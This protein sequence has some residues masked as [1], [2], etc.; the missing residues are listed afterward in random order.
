MRRYGPAMVLFLLPFAYDPWAYDV[1]TAKYGA[2]MV[3]VGLWASVR[4]WE[5][6]LPR[7]SGTAMALLIGLYLPSWVQGASWAHTWVPWSQ[8]L[9][10]VWWMLLVWDA[11]L[12]SEEPRVLQAT[13]L[14]ASAMGLVSISLLAVVEWWHPQ[15]FVW[16]GAVRGLSN[17]TMGNPNHLGALLSVGLPIF[18]VLGRR[19]RWGALCVVVG[20]ATTG[21]RLSLLTAYILMALGAILT[22]CFGGGQ[23]LRERLQTTAWAACCIGALWFGAKQLTPQKQIADIAQG[24][25][26]ISA[27]LHLVRCALPMS[28][29]ALPWGLGYGRFRQRFPAHRGRCLKGT[30]FAQAP[31]HTVAVNL[32]NDWLQIAL[33]GGL[34][35]VS[36]LLAV[37]LWWGLLLLRSLRMN[38][39]TPSAQSPQFSG[40][41]WLLLPMLGIFVQMGGTFPIQLPSVLALAT[42]CALSAQHAMFCASSVQQAMPCASSSRYT[43][44]CARFARYTTPFRWFRHSPEH[45]APQQATTD[46]AVGFYLKATL[47]WGYW[48]LWLVVMFVAMRVVRA[49]HL[50]VQGMRAMER[51]SSDAT[52]LLQQ[53]A[54]LHPSEQAL[55]QLGQA[56]LASRQPEPAI[57][58]LQRA[59][60]IFPDVQVALTLAEAHLALRNLHHARRDLH[61]ARRDL[62]HARRD[63]RHARL[64][65]LRGLALHPHHT[66]T[67][68]LLRHIQKITSSTKKITPKMITPVLPPTS[69][70]SLHPF[71]RQPAPQPSDDPDLWPASQPSDDPDL[72]PR[73]Q[74][75][76]QPSDL[77]PRSQP[78]TQTTPSPPQKKHLR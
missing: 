10:L 11:L 4:L 61:H 30:V 33:E 27:R 75:A 70:P 65:L 67:I 6:D 20:I 8:A 68:S 56:Q 63:L 66:E 42:L 57:D 13:W 37:L 25:G 12:Q 38:R 41:V 23:T 2:W 32:H 44:I 1:L 22:C 40:N 53:S 74:P 52:A 72:W 50:L 28:Q 47:R 48:V 16:S 24:R 7:Y 34:L 76:S 43:A 73:S 62:R 15:A 78:T 45:P 26:G 31:L 18:F 60:A 17:A 49:E 5:G 36:V 9:A 21:S 64:W 35:V 59:Y 3:C 46:A 54:S 29:E 55:F 39:P 19:W 77:W 69:P 58:S 51:R 14:R 71:P